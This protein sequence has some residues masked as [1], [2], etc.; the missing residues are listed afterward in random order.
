MV[1]ISRLLFLQFQLLL[2]HALLVVCLEGYG[3]CKIRLP[4]EMCIL[5]QIGHV[6]VYPFTNLHASRTWTILACKSNAHFIMCF[7]P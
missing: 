5:L 2:L 6:S 1:H 4:I 7:N 3:I